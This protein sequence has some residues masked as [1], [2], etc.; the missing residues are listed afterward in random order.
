[1]EYKKYIDLGFKRINMHDSVE[2]K[3][4]GY[5]GFTLTKEINSIISVEVS[6]GELDKPKMYIKKR[7][8]ETCHIIPITSE[9]VVDLLSETSEDIPDSPVY[10][11]LKHTKYLL[12]RAVDVQLRR[13]FNK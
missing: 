2:Y 6:S 5:P 7:N 13:K 3:Q 8:S 12:S 10:E 9:T 4:T 1:M 11:V